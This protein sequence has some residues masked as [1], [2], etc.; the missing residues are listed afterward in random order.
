MTLDGLGFSRILIQDFN[1]EC[2]VRQIPGKFFTRT[3]EIDDDN[4]FSRL[5]CSIVHSKWYILSLYAAALSMQWQVNISSL[6]LSP[7]LHVNSIVVSRKLDV[8][9]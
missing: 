3:I 7:A 5:V 1:P 8:H 6:A 2:I 4:F 9:A